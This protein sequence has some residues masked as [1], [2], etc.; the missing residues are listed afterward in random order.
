MNE[1]VM[2]FRIGMFVIVAGLVLTMLIVWFAR[3]PQ[4][5]PRPRATSRSTTPRPGVAEELQVR[6]SGI[7][8]RGGRVDRLRRPAEP[9]RRRARH[10]SR[11]RAKFKIKAGSV[12]RLSRS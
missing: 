11:W 1:R 12:P 6:K 3:V 9:A 2:Q 10:A 4:M 8:G 7:R 5:S